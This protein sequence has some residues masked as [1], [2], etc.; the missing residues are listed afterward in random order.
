MSSDHLEFVQITRIAI[1][2]WQHG[3]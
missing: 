3:V 2:A 1:L